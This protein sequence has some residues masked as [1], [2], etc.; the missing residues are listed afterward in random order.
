M[1]TVRAD[2]S[3]EIA[4]S[5]ERLWDLLADVKSWPEWQGTSY[6]D[7][8]LGP[9]VK[10]CTFV[11][12]LGGHRWNLTVTRADK[13]QR[14]S[15]AGRQ[16]GLEAI[17]DWEFVE[18]EGKTGAASI[19]SVSGW[20]LLFVRRIVEKKVSETGE[21]WLAELKAKAESGLA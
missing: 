16:T 8:P 11:A 4:S 5:A 3:V 6:V 1:P 7:P 19:D 15:W 18:I 13:P 20:M 9:L 2:H 14:L 10:G 12:D 21:K 17:H